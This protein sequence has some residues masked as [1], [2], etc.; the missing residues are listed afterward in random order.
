MT[1]FNPQSYGSCLG[2]FF[3]LFI[4]PFLFV[5]ILATGYMGLI[6]IK[7]EI[8]TLITISLIFIIYMFFIKHNASH[9]ACT[10]SN[11]FSLMED[12]LKDA[13]KV[14]ALAIMGKV[15]ST[16]TVRDFLE[17]Y[18]KGIRDDNFAKVAS[19][20][21]P[22][23]GILGT[24]IAIAISMPDFTVSSTQKLDEEISVLLSGIGT[25]F[26][27]SIY[28]IFLSLWWVFFER[29]GLAR[30][31]KSSLNLE[32]LYG[33]KIWKKSELIKHEHMQ[34][35]L[36]D[37]KIIQTM[38]ETFSLDFIKDL[39]NQYIRNMKT[40]IDDST[41]SFDRITVHMESVS[42][43]LR[44]TMGEMNKSNESVQ[45]I[46]TM[47][48]DIK[49]FIL[50]V[51]SLNRGFEDFNGSVDHTFTKIDSELANAVDKLSDMAEIIVNQN[52]DLKQ[53]MT[54]IEQREES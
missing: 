23:L 51:K 15:K 49:D 47:K 34:T 20:V 26:Y 3:V 40:I 10:I 54:M 43:D 12:N 22:M 8:H 18:F 13:L 31:E 1:K 39:N 21:F 27:A 52:R 16:L 11:N 9:T 50:S 4:F 44:R 45:A 53:K 36:K 25:A 6:P 48:K 29:R 28:G 37:Q 14:N 35:E 38:K 19:S 41:N 42:R 7:V 24:F 32:E 17:E 46:D 33:S 5:S 30:I 2:I